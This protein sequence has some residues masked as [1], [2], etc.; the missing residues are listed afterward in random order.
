MA[1]S[2]L[3]SVT[4]TRLGIIPLAGAVTSRVRHN[5]RA[6]ERAAL[7]VGSGLLLF[8]RN[9]PNVWAAV[10]VGAIISTVTFFSAR[11]PD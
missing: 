4:L 1:V 8:A 10:A 11:R 3:A 6:H 7:L 2:V 5:L 9:T